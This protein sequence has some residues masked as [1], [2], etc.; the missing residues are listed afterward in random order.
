VSRTRTTGGREDRR[1]IS[2]DKGEKTITGDRRGTKVRK[3]EEING[4]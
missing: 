2:N 1:E 3:G 4:V